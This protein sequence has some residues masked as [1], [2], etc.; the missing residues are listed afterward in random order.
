MF[1]NLV[2]VKVE[3]SISASD[4]EDINLNRNRW[5]IPCWFSL[6]NLEMV[7]AVTLAFFNIQQYFIRDIHAKFGIPNYASFQVLG[8]AQAGV[9]LT[10]R[11]LVSPL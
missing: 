9:F 2:N 11:F 7:K 6:I 8:K 1:L 4:N 3:N 5:G 10:S